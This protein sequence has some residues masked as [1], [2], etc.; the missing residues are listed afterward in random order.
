MIPYDELV[1]RLQTWR[2][3]QGL[4]T[5]AVSTPLAPHPASPPQAVPDDIPAENLEV[6]DDDYFQRSHDFALEPLPAD[7]ATPIGGIPQPTRRSY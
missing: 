2:A 1:A 4:P 3:R 5:S 7:E 6:I